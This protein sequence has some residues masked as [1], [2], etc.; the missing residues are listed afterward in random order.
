MR[1]AHAPF[2]LRESGK[3]IRVSRCVRLH[4]IDRRRRVRGIDV[5][6]RP[7]NAGVI[8][9]GERVLDK[10][11]LER[12]TLLREGRHGVDKRVR[13]QT[14]RG[15][16]REERAGYTR[17]RR[18][19]RAEGSRGRA[20]VDHHRRRRRR[21]RRPSRWCVRQGADVARERTDRRAGGGLH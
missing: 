1:Q 3:Q 17:R 7:E 8:V 9:D 10:R 4:A 15:E 19:C 11:G 14:G 5:R 16:S 6:L 2:V 13:E 18:R 20:R 21:R 12:Y